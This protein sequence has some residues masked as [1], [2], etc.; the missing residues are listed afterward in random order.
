MTLL[1]GFGGGL[2][3]SALSAFFLTAVL[4]ERAVFKQPSPKSRDSRLFNKAGFFAVPERRV[5]S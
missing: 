3:K 1:A 5:I 2:L 4:W